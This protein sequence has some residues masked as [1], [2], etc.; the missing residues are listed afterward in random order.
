MSCQ[1]PPMSLVLPR[2]RTMTLHLPTLLAGFTF[3]FAP[4]EFPRQQG[5]DAPPIL[6]HSMVSAF[7]V[8]DTVSLPSHGFAVPHFARRFC[9]LLVAANFPADKMMCYMLRCHL[10]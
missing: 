2:I 9:V 1:A 10:E 5:D 6:H 7:G 3:L 8:T 4:S